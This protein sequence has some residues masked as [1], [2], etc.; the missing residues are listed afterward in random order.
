MNNRQKSLT[1]GALVHLGLSLGWLML[2]SE[3][4][5]SSF[6]VGAAV[7]Y[8]LLLWLSPVLSAQVYVSLCLNFARF[9][10]AFAV[11]FVKS[12]WTLA[13][14]V[15]GKSK[16]SIQPAFVDYEVAH[17]NSGELF[18]LAH[19]ITLTPGTTSVHVTHDRKTLVV[20]AFDG[21]NPNDVRDSIR[22]EL[23]TPI[24]RFTRC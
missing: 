3:P 5:L 18:L 8:A 22:V 10:V 24:L 9:L 16:Q 13:K 21:A 11:A 20:H 4:S 17:L 2:S 23:E 6:F 15:L 14:A 7:G 1:R 12:N 19:C